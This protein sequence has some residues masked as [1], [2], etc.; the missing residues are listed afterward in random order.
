MNFHS[1]VCCV[2]LLQFVTQQFRSPLIALVVVAFVSVILLFAATT[3]SSPCTNFHS[4]Q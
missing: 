1:L 2:E 4:T 3:C